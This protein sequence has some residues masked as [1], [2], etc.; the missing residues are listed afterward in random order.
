M[1]ENKKGKKWFLISKSEES[2]LNKRR[3]NWEGLGGSKLC[4]LCVCVGGQRY[5]PGKGEHL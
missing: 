4:V 1:Q 5:V 2:S 3:L